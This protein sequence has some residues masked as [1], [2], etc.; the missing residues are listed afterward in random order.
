[1]EEVKYIILDFGKVL[2]KPTT[3]HWFITPK[4]IELVDMN[5]I[6][7]SKFNET[8]KMLD[9]ILARKI[10]TKE[11]EYA[12]F[13]EF[14]D[15]LLTILNYSNKN[16]ELVSALAYDITYKS[17]KYTMYEGVKEELEYLSNKY[18]LILLSD[19]WPCCIDIMKEYEIYEYFDR[20]YISSIYGCEKKDGI[21]FDFPI[22]DYNIKSGEAIFVDDNPELLSVAL[23]KGLD[24]RLMNRENKEIESKYQ[25]ITNLKDIEL[26]KP[27]SI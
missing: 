5:K 21:F 15:K 6:D 7:I 25:V 22:K 24:V 12:T 16:N 14:Y 13:Y 9:D 1:M 17:S 4:F 11:E 2:A 20:L 26:S 3:G 23:S 18:T 8:V 27:K 19:N 10:V